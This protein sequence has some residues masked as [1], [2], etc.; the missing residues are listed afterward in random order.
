MITSIKNGIGHNDFSDKKI[1]SVEPKENIK[2][3]NPVILLIDKTTFSAAE[4]FALA[5]RELPHVKLV[6]DLTA[7]GFADADWKTIS[8][9]WEVCIP[10]G[11]FTDKS[12]FCWEGIGIPPNYKIRTDPT[13]QIN[14]TDELI[15]LSINLISNSKK[16]KTSCNTHSYNIGG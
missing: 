13:K 15:E 4:N 12:G 6:G 2:Y 5:M 1:W 3:L 7:G 10:F 8:C 9:G 16:N 14:G 11:V